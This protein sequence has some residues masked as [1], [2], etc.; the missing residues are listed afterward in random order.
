MSE[1]KKS[2]PC[3]LCEIRIG[4]AIAIDAHFYGDDCPYNCSRY[5][6]WKSKEADLDEKSK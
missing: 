1:A 4:Y 2:C 6:E 3:D 5:E